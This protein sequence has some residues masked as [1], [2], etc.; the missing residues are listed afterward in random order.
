MKNQINPPAEKLLTK[1][2]SQ[3]AA[4]VYG[5]P[6]SDI[7]IT[8][9]QDTAISYISSYGKNPAS[10]FGQ[11]KA[12]APSQ[13]V[14]ILEGVTA[15]NVEGLKKSLSAADRKPAFAIADPPSSPAN[16]RLLSNLRAAGVSRSA[17]CDFSQAVNPYDHDCWSGSSSVVRYDVQKVGNHAFHPP[18][19]SCLFAL[20]I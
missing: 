15:Q 18:P 3:A 7:P 2:S 1:D 17:T 5:S 19:H 8:I 4:G 13:L 20:M 14:V 12:K 16:D 11:D 6:L 10:L 9:D